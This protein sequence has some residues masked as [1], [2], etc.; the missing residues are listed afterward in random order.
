[1]GEQERMFAGLCLCSTGLELD[2]KVCI[3]FL[4]VSSIH[5]TTSHALNL[6]PPPTNPYNVTITP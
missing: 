6:S 5:R 3:F 2:I 4:C 1:M